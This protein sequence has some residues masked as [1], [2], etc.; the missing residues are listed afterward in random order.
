MN[1]VPW[2]RGS[3]SSF[4]RLFSFCYINTSSRQKFSVNLSYVL[5]NMNSVLPTPSNYMAQLAIQV[6]N[7]EL[8]T[9]QILYIHVYK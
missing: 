8:P 7:S 6:V 1:F 5:Y 4:A 2:P 3:S 9:S